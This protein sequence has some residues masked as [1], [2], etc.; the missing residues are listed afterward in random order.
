[1]KKIYYLT[2]SYLPEKSGGV[3]MRVA[4]VDLFI[5]NG[6]DVTVIT[7]CYG[8]NIKYEKNI[9]YLPF[10]MNKKVKEIYDRLERIGVVEDYLDPWIKTA[11]KFLKGR[12]LNK[13]I[14]FAT[15]GGDLG[16][17][18]L[19]SLLKQHI[20]CKY[21]VNFRDPIN[22]SLV[23]GL[24][25]NN[26]F[27]LSREKHEKKYLKNADLIITS[28]KT[29]SSSLKNKYKQLDSKIVNNYF[30]YI[31]KIKLLS[32][33]S[34]NKLRIAYSGNFRRKQSPDILARA[35][36][37]ISDIEAYFIGN[38]KHCDGLKKYSNIHN[39]MPFLEHKEFLDFMQQN[40]DV[41]F[42][43]LTNDYLGACVPS[44]IYE[45]INLGLPILG[46]L[47]EGDAM[48]I[49]NKNGYGI[50][51]R[52]DDLN[53][54]KNAIEQMKNKRVL[55]EYKKNILRDKESWSMEKRIQEVVSLLNKL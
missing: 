31:K 41:G 27:H 3:L 54:L 33:K 35:I 1:M 40:I 15:S 28:S 6:F 2:R 5:K 49:I 29:N 48:D 21:V 51:Y 36:E 47:P 32:K 55:E 4:A 13:D 9:V 24:K 10:V 44:K 38:Y 52:Y 16:T 43:S 46:A 12:V 7:M 20:G 11:Y 18:K 8:R 37:D 39:F 14:I 53:F 17:I 42:V 19:G 22:Y 26:K 25:V 30:G 23:N 50:A 34:S 45:Y